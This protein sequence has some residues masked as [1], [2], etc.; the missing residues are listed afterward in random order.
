VPVRPPIDGLDLPGVH[1]L[2]TMGD[3]FTLHHALTGNARSAIIVGGGYIGNTPPW[4][5]AVLR[6]FRVERRTSL[7][8]SESTAT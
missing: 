3:T 4:C 1:M 6:R 5:S 7:D 8:G 2:H